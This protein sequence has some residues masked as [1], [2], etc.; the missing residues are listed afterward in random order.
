MRSVALFSLLWCYG[1][2]LFRSGRVARWSL[3]TVGTWRYIRFLSAIFLF[4]I[5]AGGI[6]VAH[7]ERILF[8][9]EP[10]VLALAAAFLHGQPLYPQP[11]APVEYGLLYGPATYL[12][13][14]P[15]MLAGAQRLG[16]Y[17]AWAVL[18]LAG[19]FLF[20]Y[21]S[22]RPLGRNP[23]IAAVGLAASSACLFTD[24]TW[25][26][27]GDVW[28]VLCI[29]I[30]LWAGRRLSPWNALWVVALT[31]AMM[32]NCKIT[33]L[34]L[35]L[36]PILVLYQR[37]GRYRA[38]AYGS[39]L[40]LFPLSALPFALP[41]VS[42][43]GYLHLL[44]EA[45]HHGLAVRMFELNLKVVT[46]LL[47]PTLVF[48]YAA[49][50]FARAAMSQW[51]RAHSL[52]LSALGFALIFSIATGSKNGAG[53]YH[54]MPF[55]VPLA[56]LDVE[57]WDMLAAHNLPL[58]TLRPVAFALLF[59]AGVTFPILALHDVLAG[60]KQRTFDAPPF[61]QASPRAIED[62]LL[63]L[64]HRYPHATFQAGYSDLAHYNV[65]FLRPILQ[66]NGSPLII[67]SDTRNEAALL[68]EPVQPTL[69]QSLDHCPVDYWL[70]P[71]GGEPF[72][73][74]SLYFLDVRRGT[75]LLYPATFRKAFLHA[76]IQTS[77]PS[78]FFNVWGCRNA[79]N[80]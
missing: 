12:L 28:I 49:S 45:M 64:M 33:T 77:I 43:D 29:A 3:P 30:G 39:L 2:F 13:Y 52:Y 60:I 61:V 67:D 26:I 51:L 56:L 78:E 38:S 34:P 66:I 63:G 40:L 32:V 18:A 57:L 16:F 17:Q 69:L 41:G 9:D 11:S 79:A 24:H 46:V 15:P 65:T 5:L 53:P 54:C 71:K 44:H 8:H 58:K 70:I 22:A 31:G 74:E 23:A 76:Y 62:D 25:A 59:A 14:L 42:F 19:V 21:L 37:A 36:L 50:V 6:F 7:S 55:L 35:A 48:L 72:S 75:R 73:M 20:V 80:R 47:L 10:S 4:L 68:S 27:K 1:F